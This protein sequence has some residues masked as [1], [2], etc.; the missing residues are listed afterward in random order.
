MEMMIALDAPTG[1]YLLTLLARELR[2]I[3]G[4]VPSEWYNDMLAF[5]MYLRDN[6]P[7]EFRIPV[8]DA[9]PGVEYDAREV[10]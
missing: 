4:I 10:A 8:P 9:A 2:E 6:L 5:A 1:Y 7:A 3:R